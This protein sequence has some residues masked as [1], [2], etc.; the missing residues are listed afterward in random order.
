[1][2]E[3]VKNQVC[4]ENQRSEQVLRKKKNVHASKLA[5]NT[6][7]LKKQYIAATSAITTLINI[8]LNPTE[9]Q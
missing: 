9:T 5:W 6:V 1:M 7:Y 8:S 3:D 2:S 4:P